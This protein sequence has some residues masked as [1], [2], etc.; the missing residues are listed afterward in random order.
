MAAFGV[1]GARRTRRTYSGSSLHAQ[2]RE[3]KIGTHCMPRQCGCLGGNQN[4]TFCYGSGYLEGDR[5]PLSYGRKAWG[6]IKASSPGLSAPSGQLGNVKRNNPR[7]GSQG[8]SHSSPA[9]VQ[10]LHTPPL[11]KQSSIGRVQPHSPPRFQIPPDAKATVGTRRVAAPVQGISKAVGRTPDR[12]ARHLLVICPKC[13]SP[14]REDRLKR[15]LSKQ[16]GVTGESLRF[17]KP[18]KSESASKTTSPRRLIGRASREIATNIS[19]AGALAAGKGHSGPAP[20][21]GDDEITLID[22]YWE[23]RRLDGSRDYWQI[24]EEGRFGSHPSFDACDDE[25]AP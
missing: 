24:R 10:G 16:H 14:V 9:K 12:R 1:S 4:C 21:G 22:N 3:D 19:R 8:G 25:S 13:P 20:K 7:L 18:A 23:E 11:A 6:P 17:S 5:L 2:P 15:H